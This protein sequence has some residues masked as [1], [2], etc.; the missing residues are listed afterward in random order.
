[1]HYPEL[2]LGT[3]NLA[4]APTENPGVSDAVVVVAVAE[5]GFAKVGNV[6]FVVVPV[7]S[8]HFPNQPRKVRK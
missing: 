7:A 4:I 3:W 2:R 1:M 6:A 8:R 5:L